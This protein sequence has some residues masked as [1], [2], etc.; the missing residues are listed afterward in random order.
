MK[1][2]NMTREDFKQIPT[3]SPEQTATFSS[4]VIIPTEEI[5]YSGWRCMEFVAVD[6]SGEPMYKMSGY[7]DVLHIDG[8]GGYGEHD[9][10]TVPTYVEAKGW[11][12]DCLPCGYLRLMCNCDMKYGGGISDFQIYGV[13]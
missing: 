8:I 9:W 6:K 4:L 11:S 1:I 3:I 13:K 5:H 7:S 10:R 12:F 2:F